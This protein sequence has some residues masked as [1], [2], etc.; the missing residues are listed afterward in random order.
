MSVASTVKQGP[1]DS[2]VSRLLEAATAFAEEGKREKAYESSLKATALA[3]DEPLAWYLRSRSAA[4]K[5]EQ[6]MC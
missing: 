2:E 6:L 1:L 4:S 5:E 3:P